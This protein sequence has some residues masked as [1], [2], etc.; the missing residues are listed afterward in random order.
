MGV[1][2]DC[3]PRD[4]A[5]PPTLERCAISAQLA[6]FRSNEA[7]VN[8]APEWV[9]C[10]CRACLFRSV[11]LCAL[12]RAEVGMRARVG[13]RV[14]LPGVRAGLDSPQQ[15]TEGGR[16]GVAHL[17]RDL[18]DALRRGAQQMDGVAVPGGTPDG[19]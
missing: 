12:G 15:G 5:S 14:R 7:A 1:P 11:D 6:S 17:R 8:A 3:E 18:L 13:G 10:A 2:E 4:G 19:G 9:I 16:V